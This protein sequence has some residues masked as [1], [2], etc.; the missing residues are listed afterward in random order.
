MDGE[1]HVWI[2]SRPIV[3][4]TILAYLPVSL[5]ETLGMGDLS[6]YDD[7]N[8]VVLLSWEHCLGVCIG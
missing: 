2:F 4:N 3:V 1:I 7:A 8:G 5:E 6:P